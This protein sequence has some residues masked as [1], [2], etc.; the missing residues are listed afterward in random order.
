MPVFNPLTDADRDELIRL[1]HSGEALPAAWRGRLF[2]DSPR[3]IKP[4][5]HGQLSFDAR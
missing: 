4:V 1:I 3:A 5:A 2:P